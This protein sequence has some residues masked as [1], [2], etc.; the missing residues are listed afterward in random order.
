MPVPPLDE[1]GNLPPG[2]H[3]ATLAEVER[4]FGHGSP[5]RDWLW[6]KLVEVVEVARTSGKV[7]RL[8][9]WGSFVTRKEI[10]GDLDLFLVTDANPI[11]DIT[12]GALPDLLDHER[13]RRRFQADIF[14]MKE[15]IGTATTQDVLDVYQLDRNR[16]LRGIIEVAL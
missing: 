6:K 4:V 16:R 13:A 1:S 3:L 7:K 2:V 8:I 15:S 11:Q 9:I 12:S 14:W 5:R 10:P